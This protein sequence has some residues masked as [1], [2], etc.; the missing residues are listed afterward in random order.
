SELGRG[1]MG[2]V[3]KARHLALNRLVAL[4]MILSGRHTGAEYQKRF[5]AEAEVVARLKHPH[6]VEIHDIGEADGLPYFALEFLEGGSLSRKLDGMPMP[7]HEA[8]ALI[9]TLARAVEYAHAQGVVHRDLKPGNVVLTAA[10]EPKITDFGLAKQ[11]D[12]QPGMAGAGPLTATG[13]V[14]G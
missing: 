10:G 1:G 7:P 6:I 11:L 2:V 14:V 3:Y 4:K 8:A 12:D 13:A 9:E 5:R